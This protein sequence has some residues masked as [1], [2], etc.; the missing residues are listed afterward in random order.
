MRKLHIFY[1][2]GP[3]GIPSDSRELFFDGVKVTP[4][5]FPNFKTCLFYRIIPRLCKPL[6][7]IILRRVTRNLSD[8]QRVTKVYRALEKFTE[9]LGSRVNRNALNASR[10]GAKFTEHTEKS[11]IKCLNKLLFFSEVR[12]FFIS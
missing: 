8:S 10:L 1:T 11:L 5:T 3:S 7:I 2:V 12:T 6:S 4:R 9:D